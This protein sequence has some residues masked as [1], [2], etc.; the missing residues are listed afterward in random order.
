MCNYFQQTLGQWNKVFFLSGGMCITTGLIYLFFGT[1]DVQKWNTYE[2]PMFNKK[3]MK[4]M[5]KKPEND[6]TQNI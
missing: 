6:S 5:V 3:E 1:S 2:S 4:L